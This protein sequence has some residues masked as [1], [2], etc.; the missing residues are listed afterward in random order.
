M[1]YIDTNYKDML[2]KHGIDVGVNM[3]GD[4]AGIAKA[5]GLSLFIMVLI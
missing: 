5:E 3:C 1:V 2:A 4:I